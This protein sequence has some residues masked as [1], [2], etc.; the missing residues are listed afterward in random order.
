MKISVVI[1]TLN[2]A[3]EL[4]VCLNQLRVAGWFV[5]E[6]IV[7]DGGS[8]DDTRVI[9]TAEGAR[10]V[11][12]PPGRGLQLQ[13]G[14]REASGQWLLFLHADTLLDSDWAVVAQRFIDDPDKQNRAGVFQLALNDRSNAARCLERIVTWRTRILAL[15]YGDQGLMLSRALYDE[16]GGYTALPI[17]EDV[18]II[19]R[20]GRK[21]VVCLESTAT[22]S[23]KRYLRDGW[24]RRSACNLF[25]LSLYYCGVSPRLIKRLYG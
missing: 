5:A 1:P 3:N 2:A 18:D 4:S 8:V 12:C 7:V 9:A 14:A 6:V 25:C 21:R 11:V 24:R 16:V 17:M 23:A 22:T 13:T 10:V 19:R 20:L 15:P